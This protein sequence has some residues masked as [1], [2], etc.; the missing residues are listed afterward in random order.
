M[1]MIRHVRLRFSLMVCVVGVRDL[2][3]SVL[4]SVLTKMMESESCFCEN[5]ELI[6]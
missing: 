1:V 5:W 3:F 6:F 2:D 4:H